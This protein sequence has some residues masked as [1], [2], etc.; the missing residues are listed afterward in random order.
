MP[1]SAVEALS[2]HA[3]DVWSRS[4][5]PLGEEGPSMITLSLDPTA[6]RVEVLRGIVY[7]LAFLAALRVAWRRE[8]A[9]AAS[10]GR[11]PT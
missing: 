5:R 4:L 2:P 7:L 6:T 1:R 10:T 11:A 9:V 3:A 8:G